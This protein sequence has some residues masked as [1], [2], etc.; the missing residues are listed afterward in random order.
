V[1]RPPS[2]TLAFVVATPRGLDRM[3]IFA[4]A[5][6]AIAI[7][8]LVLPLLDIAGEALTTPVG[9]VLRHHLGQLGTFFLSFVVISRLWTAHHRAFEHVRLYDTVLVRLTMLWLVTV[10]FLPFPTEL[11]GSGSS[12]AAVVLYIGT[13]LAS[14]LVL[15]VTIEYVHLHRALQLPPDEMEP[16]PPAHWAFPVLLAVALA[17]ALVNA[18]AGLWALLLL[19]VSGPLDALILRLRGGRAAMV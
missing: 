19:L 11:L 6:V 12:R 13:L 10:V 1:C 5:V 3:V 2:G 9:E 4:D 15:A 16:L 17:I 7:T 18:H 14:S 8:L